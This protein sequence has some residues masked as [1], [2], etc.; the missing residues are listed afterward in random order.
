MSE[1][2][3]TADQHFGHQNIL[4]FCKRPFASMDEM[5]EELIARNN[6]NGGLL[7]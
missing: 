2:F 6:A 7:S 1:I 5:R 3:F 4:V